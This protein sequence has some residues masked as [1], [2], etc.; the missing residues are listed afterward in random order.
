M[1]GNAKARDWVLLSV[2]G[3]IWGAS[4]MGV[5]VALEDIGPL[6]VAAGRIAIGAILVTFFA[7]ISKVGLPDF[8]MTGRRVWLHCFGFAVFTNALPFSLLSW[9]QLEVTSGFAGITMAVVP[10]FTLPLA[11]IILEE[12]MG[13]RKVVGFLLGFL[14]VLVLIG[15]NTLGGVG[16][17]TENI[18]RLACVCASLCYAIGTMVT[19][20]CPKTPLLSYSA[21]G[22]ILATLMIVPISLAFE[23][24]PETI[25]L[26]SGLG[27]LYLGIFP[28]AVATVL[29]VTVIKSAGPTFLSLVNYQVPIWAVIFGIAFLS[30]SLPPTFIAA[31]LLILAGLA[32]SQSRS[33]GKSNRS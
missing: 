24:I 28:T 3:V 26:R 2:L 33:K 10:L 8:S 14:G 9:A 16:T 13:W 30:E 17:Q 18:A 27:L 19:R 5:S 15:P 20:T 32:I 12:E 1:N 25:T 6:S 23:G 31:L 29:L 21:G 7:V 11:W 4:F 22:L